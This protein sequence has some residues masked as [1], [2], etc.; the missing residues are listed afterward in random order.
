MELFLVTLIGLCFG[1]FLNVAILRIPKG[2]SINFPSSHCP[3]CKHPL[4][5]YH[6]IPLFSWLFLRGKCAFCHTSISL[7]YPLIELL[8]ALIFLIIFIKTPL[9][10]EALLLGAIFALLLALSLI[11]LRYKAVPDTLSLPALFLSFFVGSPLVSFQNALLFMG[12]FTLL[13]FSISSIMKKEVMGEADIIIAGIIGALLGIKLG[14]SSIY[15]SAIIALIAF[16]IVRKKGY[17]LPFIPFL[18]L[19]LFITWLFD[20]EILSILGMIYA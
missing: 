10:N 1:S 12:G 14:C 9:V 15:L 6:N 19:G 8:G 5:W 2:E 20:T 3:T 13:R 16:V 18:S 17:E 4:K 7:Q 11:D